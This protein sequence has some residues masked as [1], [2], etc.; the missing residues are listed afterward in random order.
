MKFP[1]T[2]LAVSLAFAGTQAQ[3]QSQPC[4]PWLDDIAAIL[5]EGAEV[6]MATSSGGQGVAAARETQAREDA[7]GDTVPLQDEAAERAAVDEADAAGE[8]GERIM[9]AIARLEMERAELDK[10]APDACRAAVSDI[11]R[12][13][14]LP[15]AE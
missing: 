13:L 1:T 4:G 14:V 9:R 11:I 2:L 7:E 8:G 12:V 3:A 15:D 6:S 10:E 5:H